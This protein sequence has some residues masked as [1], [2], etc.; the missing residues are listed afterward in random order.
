MSGEHSKGVRVRPPKLG[1]DRANRPRRRRFVA[2]TAL[3]SVC[4]PSNR[5]V[6]I[7]RARLVPGS[8]P[9]NVALRPV[10]QVRTA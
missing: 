4:E 7:E 9:T 10:V 3:A 2:M 1:Q 6:R 5:P 8:P